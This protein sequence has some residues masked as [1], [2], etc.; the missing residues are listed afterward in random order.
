MIRGGDRT[1]LS[2]S[3]WASIRNK[4]PLL[5]LA[6][7]RSL[8]TRGQDDD[9]MHGIRKGRS[10][11][12]VSC[13]ETSK[14]KLIQ[15]VDPMIGKMQSKWDGPFSAGSTEWTPSLREAAA[16][17]TIDGGF[18]MPFSDFIVL[19]DNMWTCTVP[20]TN[21]QMRMNESILAFAGA[22]P[23]PTTCAQTCFRGFA[24]AQHGQKFE[25]VHSATRAPAFVFFGC[26][27]LC[28]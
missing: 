14:I 8:S 21:Q 7:S 9:D 12:V 11:R 16:K 23:P 17:V 26:M 5:V 20:C 15:L 4:G 10:F 27:L 18:W 3:V 25:N 13:I 2:E 28:F 24:P 22:I 1:Q 19:F 6:G